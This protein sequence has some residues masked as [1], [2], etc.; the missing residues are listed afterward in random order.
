L[1]N[2]HIV[3][4]HTYFLRNKIHNYFENIFYVHILRKKKR[5]NTKLFLVV[6]ELAVLAKQFPLPSLQRENGTARKMYLTQK[7][8]TE[9]FIK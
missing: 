6:T 9:V 2:S 4:I 8:S 7:T 5:N 1:L 3:D